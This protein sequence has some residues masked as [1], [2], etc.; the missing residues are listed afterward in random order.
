MH[1]DR[2]VRI[3]SRRFTEQLRGGSTDHMECG[4][5]RSAM[6]P[7]SSALAPYRTAPA[8]SAPYRCAEP[9]RSIA[10]PARSITELHGATVCGARRSCSGA[11]PSLHSSDGPSVD[12][13]SSRCHGTTRLRHGGQLTRAL[14]SRTRSPAQDSGEPPLHSR[15]TSEPWLSRQHAAMPLQNKSLSL[16]STRQVEQ[17]VGGRSELVPKQSACALRQSDCQ[18]QLRSPG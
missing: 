13:R 2:R 5:E 11:A 10:E 3:D 9:S 6:T 14:G 4:T 7:R 16:P 17:G 18:S 15:Y 8:R 1:P 12:H